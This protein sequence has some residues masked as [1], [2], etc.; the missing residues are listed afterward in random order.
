MVLVVVLVLSLV[1]LLGVELVVPLLCVDSRHDE[2]GGHGRKV[3]AC[4]RS[5]FS[6][7]YEGKGKKVSMEINR[8]PKE[9]CV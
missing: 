1:R 4:V 5:V 6:E 8:V 9:Y 2:V 7:N 3:V